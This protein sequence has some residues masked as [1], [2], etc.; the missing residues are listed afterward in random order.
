[1]EQAIIETGLC[2]EATISSKLYDAEYGPYV[3]HYRDDSR[4]IKRYDWTD[5]DTE[6]IAL[7]FGYPLCITHKCARYG[8]GRLI[9]LRDSDLSEHVGKF[10]EAWQLMLYQRNN[11]PADQ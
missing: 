10:E 11:G 6:D 7:M 2:S 8:D 1:M 9:I 5:K 3:V 4:W